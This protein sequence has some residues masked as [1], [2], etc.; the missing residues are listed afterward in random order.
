M[1]DD[2]HK[3]I[4]AHR[5]AF[6]AAYRPLVTGEWVLH[7]CDNPACVRPDHL[8]IGDQPLNMADMSL[9]GRAARGEKNFRAKLS[10]DQVRA[11]REDG[12]SNVQIGA[13]YGVSAPTVSKIKHRKLWAHV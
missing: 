5:V 13:D 10:D 11:I 1:K 12:R 4:G 9:K 7:R 3:H 6:E 2:R 8:F